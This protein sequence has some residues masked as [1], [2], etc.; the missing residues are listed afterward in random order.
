M[1]LE[2]VHVQN[3]ASPST[4]LGWTKL[5]LIPSFTSRNLAPCFLVLASEVGGRCPEECHALIKQFARARAQCHQE[6]A[7]AA[8]RAMYTRRW[9][10]ILSIGIQKAVTANLLGIDNH[11]LDNVGCFVDFDELFHVCANQSEVSRLPLR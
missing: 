4:V 5:V 2:T 9:Y 3:Q 8:A 1:K 11:S 7:R 6:S 10:A